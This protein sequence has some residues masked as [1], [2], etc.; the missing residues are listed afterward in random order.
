MANFP[1]FYGTFIDDLALGSSVAYGG[2]GDDKIFGDPTANETY[3]GEGNDLLV[4]LDFD[5]FAQHIVKGGGSTSLSPFVNFTTD[6]TASGDDILDGGT[7]KDILYGLDGNDVLYSGDG[8]DSG[9]VT[10]GTNVYTAG[11]YG[12]DGNDYVDGGRGDDTLDGGKGVDSLYGGQGADKLDGGNGADFLFG[13]EGV[14]TLKG[15]GGADRLEGGIASDILVG[16]G[17]KD[18]LFGGDG[19]DQFDFLDKSDSLRGG[20]NRDV[21]KDFTHIEGDKINLSLIDANETKAGD[22]AFKYIGANAFHHVKGEL[23]EIQKANFT[24]VEGDTNGDGKADFQ[25]EVSGHLHLL[26]GDF[27]L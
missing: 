24:L 4:G 6:G 26:K 12:G 14:D 5:P 3:G 21:I 25:I 27:I 11:L 19:G 8:N 2:E 23:H 15:G 17:G 13:G 10:I 20:G 22:Q 16:G 7:G 9:N 1:T 18:T